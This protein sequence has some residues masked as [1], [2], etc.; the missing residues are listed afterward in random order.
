MRGD[1]THNVSNIYQ[2]RRWLLQSSSQSC[3]QTRYPLFHS[4]FSLSWLNTLYIPDFR[5]KEEDLVPLKIW[6]L[7]PEEGKTQNIYW[8]PRLVRF[9][10]CHLPR[11][12]TWAWKHICVFDEKWRWET[13][14]SNWKTKVILFSRV[15][16]KNSSEF[17]INK[18]LR[19]FW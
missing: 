15:K 9:C 19:H 3:P 2:Q 4:R 5:M 17:F 10:H 16:A 18:R 1:R 12:H 13:L 7:V 14:L 11:Y 8:Q 6:Q